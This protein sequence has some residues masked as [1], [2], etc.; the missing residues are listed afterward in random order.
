MLDIS[1]ASTYAEL[2]HRNSCQHMGGAGGDTEYEAG[3]KES[4]V[5]PMALFSLDVGFF[6]AGCG[7]GAASIMDRQGCRSWTRC[8]E[9]GARPKMSERWALITTDTGRF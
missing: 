1:V 4:K 9:E 2:R 7:E 3:G 6:R 8:Y 5:M